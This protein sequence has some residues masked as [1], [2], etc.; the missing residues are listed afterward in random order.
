LETTLFNYYFDEDRKGHTDTV[1]LFEAIGRG[2]Y[3]AYTSQYVILELRRA[4]DPKGS[5]MLALIEKYKIRE[6]E[7]DGETERLADIYLREGVLPA[8]CEYDSA[9]IASATVHR[10]DC[11]V[12]YNM[13]H[14]N[15]DTTKEMTAAIN[16]REGY[17]SILI[18]SAREVL[19]D[20]RL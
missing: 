20:E 10:L 13:G 17:G 11:V 12:S 4:E 18:C 5:N 8:Y 1:R 7:A 6:L 3:E 2:E 15:R 14:I 9:H 19:N 16:K